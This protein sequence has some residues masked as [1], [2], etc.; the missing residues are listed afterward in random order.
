M[1]T[2]SYWYQ[3][4]LIFRLILES[5]HTLN[6]IQVMLYCKFHSTRTHPFRKQKVAAL[7]YR[8]IEISITANCMQFVLQILR[9]LL[10]WNCLYTMRKSTFIWN[11]R[12]RNFSL[13][14]RSQWIANALHWKSINKPSSMVCRYCRNKSLSLRHLQ[15][16]N[17][18][19]L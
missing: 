17:V 11:F 15:I 16:S 12:V 14:F 13:A 18:F 5:A 8:L 4:Q 10:F 6:R 1:D 3:F 7:V 2:Y 19:K 9:V